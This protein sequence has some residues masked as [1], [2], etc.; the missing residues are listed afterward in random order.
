MRVGQIR[1]RATVP[2]RWTA[3]QPWRNEA[4]AMDRITVVLAPDREQTR[5]LVRRGELELMRARLGPWHQADQRAA[6]T[7]LEAL[8]LWHQEQLYAV[9]SATDREASSGLHLC[10]G[11]GFGKETPAFHVEVLPRWG[12]RRGLGCFTDLRQLPLW[13]RP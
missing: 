2:Y 4:K 8:S 1:A 9:L 7:L 3:E 5:I 13:G 6:Q 11:F 10:D 12:R